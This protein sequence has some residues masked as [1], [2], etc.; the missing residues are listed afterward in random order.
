MPVT[1]NENGEIKSISIYHNGGTGNFL[2]GVYSDQGGFPSSRLGI[3]ASTLV[4]S[5]AGWQTVQL[6]SP[7]QVI[8]GQTVWLSWVF[9]NTPG[10]RYTSGTPGRA[11][12]SYTWA[13][14]MPATFGIST[15]ASNKYSIYCTYTVSTTL[16]DANI[17]DINNNSSELTFE[18]VNSKEDNSLTV[19]NSLS[20]F[21]K[22]EFK[23][24]PNP[25]NSFCYVDCSLIPDTETYILI[26]DTNGRLIT[27]LLIDSTIKKIDV[28]QLSSGI[29]YINLRNN[30]EIITKKLI[31]EK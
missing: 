11:A 8:S 7:V 25:A 3:T 12:S 23:L 2:L 4:N 15:I 19:E 27:K 17:F 10:I 20:N 24:Y 13:N 18:N 9:Q 22:I 26:Y 21:N 31:I 6:S 28:S 30:K 16:K 5:N 29:Y 14:G 1:F